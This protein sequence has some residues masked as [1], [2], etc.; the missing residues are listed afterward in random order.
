MGTPDELLK[1]LMAK[2]L[3]DRPA[4]ATDLLRDLSGLQFED[5]RDNFARSLLKRWSSLFR[6]RSR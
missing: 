5:H 3:A 1:R 6:K 2:D 4:S